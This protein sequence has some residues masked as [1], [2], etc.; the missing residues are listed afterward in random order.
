MR[1]PLLGFTPEI[2]IQLAQQGL[3]PAAPDE[4]R[5]WNTWRSMLASLYVNNLLSYS[6]TQTALNRLADAVRDWY[7]AERGEPDSDD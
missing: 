3:A 1:R 7:I 5:Q 4:L 6:A 2:E